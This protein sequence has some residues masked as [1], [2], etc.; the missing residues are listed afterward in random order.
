M[1][2]KVDLQVITSERETKVRSKVKGN[3][4]L[5]PLGHIHVINMLIIC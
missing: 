4:V 5:R 1:S 2:T 3:Y